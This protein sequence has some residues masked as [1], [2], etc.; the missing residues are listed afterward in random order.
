MGSN[1]TLN[2]SV[3]RCWHPIIFQKP[4]LADDPFATDLQEA[5]FYPYCQ[6]WNKWKTKSSSMMDHLLY[7][8]VVQFGLVDGGPFSQYNDSPVVVLMIRMWK[9]CNLPWRVSHGFLHETNFMKAMDAT[10]SHT[11]PWFN[12]DEPASSDHVERIWKSNA[13]FHTLAILT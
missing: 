10:R 13:P 2:Q 9:E 4:A 5:K 6:I 3:E 11:F 12:A 7:M 8:A 1:Q